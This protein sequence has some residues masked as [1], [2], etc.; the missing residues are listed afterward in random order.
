[1]KKKASILVISVIFSTLILAIGAGMIKI[2]VRE[3]RIFSDFYFAERAYF[4]AESATEMALVKL[5]KNSTEN[6]AGAEIFDGS[7]G[8]LSNL[9]IKNL[10]NSAE[11]ILSPHE[12][13]KLSLKKDGDSDENFAA[14]LVE[15][16]NL[17]I[18]ATENL[19]LGILCDGASI[20]KNF[21]GGS[22]FLKNFSAPHDLQNLPP[23]EILVENFWNN[24]SD[25]EKKKC[26]LSLQNAENQNEIKIF[27]TEIPPQKSE[28]VAIGQSEN[29]KKIINFSH[30]QNKF[31]KFLNFG[32]L[33]SDD[34]F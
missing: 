5:K 10:Q 21:S 11:I 34:G 13:V 19:R 3:M 16:Q 31:P 20:Q 7:S 30:F 24:F 15:M 9:K 25:D 4:A 8:I 17:Q 27:G 18:S 28:I 33:H 1:M 26:F 12:N 14:N 29:R 23:G 2:F 32:I 6:I 22:I